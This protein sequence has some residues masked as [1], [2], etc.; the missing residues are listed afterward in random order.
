M[1]YV[2]TAMNRANEA[3]IHKA[4][5]QGQFTVLIHTVVVPYPL[6][7]LG[8]SPFQDPVPGQFQRGGSDGSDPP[9]FRGFIVTGPPC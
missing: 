8:G 4:N 7:S 6:H 3:L 5:S 1:E 9:L 2:T